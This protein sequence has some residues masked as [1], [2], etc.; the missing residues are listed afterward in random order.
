MSMKTK[1][2]KIGTLL[3]AA[4]TLLLN[5]PIMAQGPGGPPGPPAGTSGPIDAGIALLLLLAATAAYG[6]MRIKR[7]KGLA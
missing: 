5:S 1:T 2:A 6:Y 4:G 3:V 7:E